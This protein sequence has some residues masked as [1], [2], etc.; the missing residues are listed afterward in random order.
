MSE[1][2]YSIDLETLGTKNG[3]Y[4]LAIGCAVFNIETGT[5]ISTFYKNVVCDN[6]FKIDYKTVMWWLEQNDEARK[7]LTEK[8]E[9]VPIDLALTELSNFITDHETAIVWGNGSIFD[10][11]LLEYAYDVYNYKYPWEFRNIRDMRTI[12]NMARA[13]GFKDKEIEFKGEKH[14]ALNDSVHQA[15][16]I[17]AAYQHITCDHHLI[18]VEDEDGNYVYDKCLKC[19]YTGGDNA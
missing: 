7:A 3:S 11:G 15:K 18:K 17:S 10:I 2:N 19:D 16:I 13:T 12:V 14:D 5:I 4:I 8:T 1:L 6:N 9:P